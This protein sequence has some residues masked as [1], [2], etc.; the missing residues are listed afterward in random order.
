MKIKIRDT[1]YDSEKEPVVLEL[2]MEERNLLSSMSPN[3]KRFISYPDN[4]E[5]IKN[6]HSKLKEWLM[7]EP[8]I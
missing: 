7:S 2:S 1:V 8:I 6:D 3:D 5:W 4:E